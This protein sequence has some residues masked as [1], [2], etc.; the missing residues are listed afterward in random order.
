MA[1]F[2]TRKPG[3]RVA[4]GLGGPALHLVI[5][6]VL[7]ARAV[8]QGAHHHRA[9]DITMQ[10]LHQHL[11]PQSR[12]EMAAPIGPGHRLGDTHPGAQRIAGRCIVRARRVILAIAGCA[13]ALPMELDLDAMV[14]VGMHRGG[15][16]HHQRVLGRYSSEAAIA[17]NRFR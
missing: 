7:G 17:S 13:A 8:I 12:H 16:A 11:L 6:G 15:R 5:R 3:R 14:T 1:R 9:V 10:E 4:G 2:T